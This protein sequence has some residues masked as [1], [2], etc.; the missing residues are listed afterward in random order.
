[1]AIYSSGDQGVINPF[2]GVPDLTQEQY[3]SAL[4]RELED[5]DRRKTDLGDPFGMYPDELQFLAN[6][7][8]DAIQKVVQDHYGDQ[9][10]KH[11]ITPQ[12]PQP[13]E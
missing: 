7:G 4:Q 13:I 12:I 9:M 1:M 8:G 6:L 10:K 5:C 2:A 3:F 11:G